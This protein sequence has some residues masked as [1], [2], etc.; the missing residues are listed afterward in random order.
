MGAWINDRQQVWW[1]FRAGEGADICAAGIP[2]VQAAR[3]IAEGSQQEP[4]HLAT[5]LAPIPEVDC[6]CQHRPMRAAVGPEPCLGDDMGALQMMPRLLDV[7]GPRRAFEGAIFG[8]KKGSDRGLM[9]I[10]EPVPCTR[11]GRSKGS[12]ASEN[13]SLISD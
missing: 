4:D 7:F 2:R 11:S 13:R 9:V 6:E 8:G 10:H 3:K 5:R 1:D 12:N